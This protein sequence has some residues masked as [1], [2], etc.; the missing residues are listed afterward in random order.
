MNSL[1]EQVL[2]FHAKFGCTVG[3]QPGLRDEALAAKLIMEE[4][5]ETCAA[6]GF[7]AYAWMDL[8]K[9]TDPDDTR[10][11]SKDTLGQFVTFRKNYDQAN[12][13]DA[14]DG[15]CDLLYVTLGAAVRL[16]IDIEPFFAE[17]QQ[18]NMAKVGGDT[19]PDGKILKPEGWQPPDIEGVL[20]RISNGR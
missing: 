7:H 18:A 19:R 17:V 2:A 1:Q 6:L 5:V 10:Q 11:T 16:G 9:P 13:I 4:A 20:E 14:I 3:E 8:R 15:I 12:L